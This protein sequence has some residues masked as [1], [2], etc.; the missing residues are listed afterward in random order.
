MKNHVFHCLLVLLLSV[1]VFYS[2]NASALG[3]YN[4]LTGDDKKFADTLINNLDIS[5]NDAYKLYD[6]YKAYLNSTNWHFDTYNNET[7]SGSKVKVNNVKYLF[8]NL[9]NTNRFVNITFIKF[10]KENE[11]LIQAVETLPRASQT[12]IDKYNEVKKDK[13]FTTST[14]NDIFSVFKKTDYTD[15]IK[16]MTNSGVG[17]IQYIDFFKLDLNS[18][19]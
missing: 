4:S 16:V 15:K 17:A 1:S 9:T 14:E 12:A 19:N 10:S 3:G 13:D 7:L 8:L 11:L 2:A 6:N 5:Q 18:K